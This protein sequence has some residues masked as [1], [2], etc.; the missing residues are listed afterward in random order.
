MKLVKLTGTEISI[1][2]EIER[3]SLSV[4]D[5]IALTH[6]ANHPTCTN[7]GI[8]CLLGLTQRGA[9]NLVRRLRERCY[10]A[11][12][13][14]GRARRIKL[15]F[16]VEHHIPGGIEQNE[17]SHTEC[18]THKPVMAVVKHE[19]S[20]EEF[21][22]LRLSLAEECFGHGLYDAARLHLV[23]VRQRLESDNEFP[24]KQKTSLLTALHQMEDRYFCYHIGSQMAKGLPANEQRAL[25]L[26]FCRA[27]HTQLASFRQKVESGELSGKAVNVIGL[28]NVWLLPPSGNCHM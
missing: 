26:R 16:R 6:I 21:A 12:T 17:K 11:Q 5:K 9:E 18:G 13:G 15:L 22:E 23:A 28:A 1:P 8:A 19:S 4:S 3:L 14:K 24:A 25:V 10:I 7:A 2:P 20:L 27:S